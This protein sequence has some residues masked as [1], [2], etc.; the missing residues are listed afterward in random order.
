MAYM[1]QEKKKM[2]QP[3]VKQILKKYGLKGSLSVRHHSTLVLTITEGPL[4]FIKNFSEMEGEKYLSD[5][6]YI[7]VNEYCLD[8]SYTGKCLDALRELKGALNQGN[9]DNSDLMTDYF[10]VGWYVD[11][12]IGKWNKDYQVK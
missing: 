10:D 8:R 11:I 12:N 1:N 9:H 2:I 7:Q 3:Q 5:R 6:Q 4:D